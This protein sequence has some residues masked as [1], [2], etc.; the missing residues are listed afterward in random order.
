MEEARKLLLCRLLQRALMA[1]QRDS[2]CS[3]ARWAAR[4]AARRRMAQS[5]SRSGRVQ[6]DATEAAMSPALPTFE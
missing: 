6:T 1:G 3:I 2:H 5:P 4:R